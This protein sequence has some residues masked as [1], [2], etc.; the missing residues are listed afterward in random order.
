MADPVTICSLMSFSEGQAHFV[1]QD[2]IASAVKSF[3]VEVLQ[4]SLLEQKCKCKCKRIP[5][6]SVTN[7]LKTQPDIFPAPPI[8]VLEPQGQD[9]RSVL[10]DMS[11]NLNL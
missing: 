11:R 10:S 3:R 7:G 5:H 4:P 6:K 9:P 1:Q 8:G 2:D